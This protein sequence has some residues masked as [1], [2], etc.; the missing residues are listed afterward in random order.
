MNPHTA[1]SSE[2]L[3][4]RIWGILQKKIFKAKEYPKCENVQLSTLESLLEKNLKLASKP[5]SKRKAAANPSKK[6]S[7]SLARHKMIG[8]LVQTSTHWLLKIIH[9]RNLPE[10][11]LQ[12]VVDVYQR[13]LTSYFDNKK[14]QLKPGFVKETFRRQPWLGHLLF[15]FL[16]EKCRSAKSEV[17]LVKALD[18]LEEILKSSLSGKGDGVNKGVPLKFLK[19]HLKSLCGL[20]GKLVINMPEKQAR[21]A[22]VRRFCGQT[23][24]LVVKQN[25]TKEFLKVLKQDAYDACDSKL[26]DLFLPFKRPE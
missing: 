22:Q 9:S 8:S 3:A 17:R 1:E 18:P 15:R 23:F 6:N 11:E 10:P 13:V 5:F 24:K 26:G 14:S 20:I 16:L 4:Q 21:R 7:A 2:Q 19:A 12:G 25:L